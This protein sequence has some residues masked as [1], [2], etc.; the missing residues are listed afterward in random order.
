MQKTFNINHSISTLT[1]GEKIYKRPGMYQ[2]ADL[3]MKA[4]NHGM[5]DELI[6]RIEKKENDAYDKTCK[7]LDNVFGV[8]TI[9]KL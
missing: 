3:I 5:L 2:L 9:W 7:Y 4:K 8:K 6:T 1:R